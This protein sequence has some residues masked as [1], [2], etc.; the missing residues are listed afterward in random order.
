M[1][2]MSLVPIVALFALY[3]GSA[4]A[5]R[6]LMVYSELLGSLQFDMASSIPESWFD[7]AEGAS[8]KPTY[9]TSGRQIYVSNS[10]SDMHKTHFLYHIEFDGLKG[11]GRWV[12]STEFNAR[13]HAVAYIESWAVTPLGIEVLKDKTGNQK[14]WEV[15]R[16]A[17]S[18]ENKRVTKEPNY[19]TRDETFSVMC[20]DDGGS[21]D[22]SVYFDSSP[23]LR[24]E[25]AGFYVETAHPYK[26]EGFQ[27]EPTV[28]A[29]IKANVEDQQQ[30]LFMLGE[31]TWMIGD[32]PGVDSGL[33]FVKDKAAYP[34]EIKEHDWRFVDERDNNSWRWDDGTIVSRNMEYSLTHYDT[35]LN[36]PKEEVRRVESG[37]IHEAVRAF[38]SIKHVPAPQSYAVLHNGIPMP[39]VGLG[40]GGLFHEELKSVLTEAFAL[41]YRVLDSAREY[42][43]EGIIG[44]TIRELRNAVF[45]RRDVFIVSKV[46]PTQLGVGPTRSAVTTSLR[47]LKSNYAD[48]YLLH[49]PACDASIDWMHCGDTEIPG[50]T[51]R[52]SWKALERE[53][54]EGRVMSIGV[55]NFD[56]GLLEELHSL[57]T[58]DPHLVQ[59]HAEMGAKQQDVEV[60]RWCDEHGAI[61]QPYAHQRNLQFLDVELQETLQQVSHMKGKSTHAVASKFFL[62]SGASVIPRS[63]DKAHLAE[64]IDL[65]GWEL[66]AADMLELGFQQDKRP[67][68]SASARDEL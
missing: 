21:V 37:D 23:T 49:W 33:A 46:W 10:A 61:Y 59:N 19:F 18:S 14:G 15:A 51:W 13:D 27:T 24:P 31:D 11:E 4:V 34:D 53:Y 48:M 16:R 6:S 39:W 5:C 50:A 7:E 25:L 55:S 65:W 47:E 44:D 68:K 62:Q 3:A 12:I 40:T 20:K 8:T 60:R 54:A 58:V 1:G 67:A 45:D 35:E 57:A 64:N 66:Q 56:R 42:N 22:R 36:G 9:S 41:G 28:Y 32:V 30:Y 38:R 26:S 29:Q 43:N 52:Q 63:R 17:P 2:K